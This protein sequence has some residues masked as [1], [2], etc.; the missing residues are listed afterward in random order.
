MA[1]KY[2]FDVISKV[3]LQEVLNAINQATREV[4]QR[5]D[6][7]NSKTTIEL[8]QADNNIVVASDSEFS[9]KSTV[10]I[11]ETRMVKR[12]VPLK[13]LS[14]GKVEDASAGTVR[15]KI[16]I[17]S[18]ITKDKCKEIVKVIK[19]AKLKVQAT[20]Q[21]EQVR[22]TSAKKDDLQEV[23]QL[24]KESPLDIHME[25]GNYR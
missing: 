15:Q 17:Q 2:S 7:K 4:S 8:N 25:F 11:L 3:D 6:L 21:D 22:I 14:F 18:G 1:A 13:A 20:I 9:L 16:D 19:A 5:Y 23:Q 12:S 24:L 10:D